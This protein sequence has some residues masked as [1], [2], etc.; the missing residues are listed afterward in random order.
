MEWA[1][2]RAEPMK[3][4]RLM[5]RIVHHLA[6][7]PSKPRRLILGELRG[8]CPRDMSQRLPASS[9]HITARSMLSPGGAGGA[10]DEVV[11]L[12]FHQLYD[13]WVIVMTYP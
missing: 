13:L 3:Q 7:P 5:E 11:H 2:K 12:F 4:L 9:G 6:V 1:K 10:T 8:R